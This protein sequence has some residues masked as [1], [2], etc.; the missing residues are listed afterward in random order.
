MMSTNRLLIYSLVA[1][2][3]VIAFCVLAFTSFLSPKLEAR[4]TT[5]MNVY[6]EEQ[7][8]KQLEAE[9]SAMIQEQAGRTVTST[10]LQR[11]LPV[12]P[13][14]DQFIMDINM[15][16]EVSG[17]RMMNMTMEKEETVYEM[18]EMSSPPAVEED[19]EVTRDEEEEEESVTEED[20]RDLV[21]DEWRGDEIEGMYKQTAAMDVRVDTYAHLVR[22][23]DELDNLTRI[24]KIESVYFT[25]EDTDDERMIIDGEDHLDFHVVV[26]TYYYPPLSDLEHE[27]PK[28]D[29]PSYE[30]RDQPFLD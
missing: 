28:A 12:V 2:V 19:V 8:I 18:L 25:R 22:F 9:K 13:L 16:E 10:E 4:D 11:R 29:Y 6:Q 5:V 1:G 27:A 15:A 3:A 23:L 24:A 21:G 26:S 14:T 20:E 17:V 30:D 7:M